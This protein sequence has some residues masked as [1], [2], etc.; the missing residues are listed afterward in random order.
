MTPDANAPLVPLAGA[1][2]M[3]QFCTFHL[4]ERR[5]GVD[6]LDVQEVALVPPLTPVH[7]APPQVAGVVNIRGQI[8]LC[9]D[10]R[11]ILGLPA[12]PPSGESR[13]I[14]FKAR[15]AEDVGA[16]VDAV[17]DIAEVPLDAIEER[18]GGDRGPEGEGAD[19]LERT[20]AVRGVCRADGGLL[21][22]L[23]PRL[24]LA[25]LDAAFTRQERGDGQT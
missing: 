13:L 24:L 11:R 21:L 17:G 4:G 2:S 19:A 8:V 10:M 20:A 23:D 15:A 1:E 22:L 12:S 7:H 16:L 6:I 3:R 9:L 18:V 14:L 25:E 5:F